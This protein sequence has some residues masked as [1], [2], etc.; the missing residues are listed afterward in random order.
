MLYLHG[1]FPSVYVPVDVMTSQLQAANAL[2]DQISELNTTLSSAM[3]FLPLSLPGCHGCVFYASGPNLQ[4]L[5]AGLL[6][7]PAA[8]LG[9]STSTSN[10]IPEDSFLWFSRLHSPLHLEATGGY[11]LP[12]RVRQVEAVAVRGRGSN[13][14]QC[15]RCGQ[16]V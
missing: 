1:N 4:T 3:A 7:D 10:L 6:L 2:E 15:G 5:T 8:V 12:A 9:G 11:Q 14:E 13:R 16:T